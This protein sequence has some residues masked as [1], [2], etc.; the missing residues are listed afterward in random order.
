MIWSVELDIPIRFLRYR[1]LLT[2]NKG[3]KE[4][5]S[6]RHILD[7]IESDDRSRIK[8]IYGSCK[9]SFAIPLMCNL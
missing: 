8:R 5:K 6:K 3:K 1:G 2:V 4:R 9:M 7:I